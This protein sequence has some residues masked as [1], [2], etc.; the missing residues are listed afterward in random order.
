MS[1]TNL[2]N[3]SH[4]INIEVL[5]FLLHID[6]LQLNSYEIPEIFGAF[7]SVGPRKVLCISYQ[8]TGI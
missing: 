8:L 5:N 7:K 4:V 3:I 1:L 2:T 6:V